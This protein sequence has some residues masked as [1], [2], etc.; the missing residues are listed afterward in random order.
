[1]KILY[2]PVFKVAVNYDVSFGRRWS[3]LE[4]LILVD[5]IGNRR[6]V[7]ELAE[8]G[9]VPERLVI[10]ALIN[11]LRVNW[12]EVRSTSQGILYT[13]TAAGARRASEGDLPAELRARSK[14]IS[15]CLDRLTG[16]WLR[17]DDLDLVHESDLPLDAVCLSPE[18][19]SIDLNN[20]SIR[21]LL[22]LDQLESLQPSELRFRFS[23]LAFAR[24]GLEFENDP[25]ALPPYC[26][27]EL[28][29][30]VSLEASDVPD[31]PSEKW[32]T[33]PKYFSREIRDDLDA[34]KIVVGGE[35]HFALV[36]R[37]L[38]NAKSIVI[39]H[40]CFISA[41]TVR[42]L[43]PDFEKAARRKI[44]VELLWGLDSDP[45]DL[46][47]NEKIKDVLQEL[48]HLT[49]HSRE[50]VKLAERS[51]YSHAKVLIYDDRKSGHWVTALGSCN[52]LSTNYDALDVSVVVRSFELT[53]RLLA[54][55][56]RTQTPAS[57]P[58][59]RLARRLNRIWNDVRRLTVSQGECGQHKLELLMDGDHYAAVR[60]ARDCA[61]DQIIL[62]C[63]LFGKAAETSAIVPMESAAKHGCNVSICYQRE[64]SFLIEEG[65]RPDAEKLNN[66]GITLLKINELHGKFLLWD[67]EGLIVSSFNWLST[68]SEGAPDL[69]AEL[70]IKF[71]GPKLRS[72]FLEALERLRGTLREQ[73]GH[74]ISVTV[75][76]VES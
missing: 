12:V 31:T 62:A 25:Q 47:K 42:R 40:S 71:E 18:I 30:R 65:A 45:E 67:D 24:V 9:N 17:S 70:G 76:G 1:M 36:Q 51:S 8:D 3:L 64:S 59:P 49:I 69:G 57:G 20:S 29:S 50:R 35:E 23:T 27:L 37:A 6:S 68:V 56:I 66:R 21:S 63:D 22:Y 28:R 75:K 2:I 5:L 15:L 43:L 38:E 39:I 34:S 74:E 41:V 4:H 60:Y 11:L 26:S 19:G 32:N 58:L 54:W 55:L 46:D 10:E 73:E 33:K 14:W 72:A 16:D 53:S 61:Q 13:A 52:F 44:R 7:V 48:K